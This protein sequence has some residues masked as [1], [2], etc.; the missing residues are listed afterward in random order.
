MA[1][2]VL[3][4][5]DQGRKNI[6]A[7]LQRTVQHFFMEVWGEHIHV[8]KQSMSKCDN[9]ARRV[10]LNGIYTYCINKQHTHVIVMLKIKYSLHVSMTHIPTSLV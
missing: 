10:A 7:R 2:V 3:N 6:I 1:K 8:G 5:T 4:I 9:K